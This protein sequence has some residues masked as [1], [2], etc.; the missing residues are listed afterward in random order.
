MVN[1]QDIFDYV[2]EK[3]DVSPDYPW[4]K[5]SNF[6][7]LRHKDNKKWFGLIMDITEDKLGIKGDN[8]IDVLNVKARKE[9]IGSLRENE[10]IF[11]AYHMDKNNWVSIVLDYTK[12]VD[13]IRDLIAES[14]ELTIK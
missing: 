13:D 10:N 4:R 12:D 2:K 6:A 3:Y 1:R 11:P 8:Q 7:A 9:F 5:F 14:Y